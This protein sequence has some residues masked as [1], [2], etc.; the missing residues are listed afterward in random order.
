MRLLSLFLLPVCLLMTASPPVAH[1]DDAAALAELIEAH[2]Q[3][4]LGERPEFASSIGE[5]RHDDRWTD[6]A[7]RAL[8]ARH[9]AD[10]DALRALRRIELSQ[11]S[12]QAAVDHALL[13]RELAW[14]I[15]MHRYGEHLLP[16]TQ[17]HGV[18]MLDRLPAQLE[19]RGLDDYDAW[20]R[21]L[22]SLDAYIAQTMA[23]MREGM[24]RGIVV[25]QAAMRR[26]PPQLRALLVDD[27]Q[28]SG[29]YA[30]FLILPAD[31][32]PARAQALRASARAAI[33]Q[34]VLPAYRRLHDFVV[35]EYLPA[36]RERVSLEALPDG[37]SWY[38][39]RVM[40]YTSTA[41]SPQ[42][43]HAI[44]VGEVERL[45]AQM[46]RTM[47]DTGYRGE[48]AGFVARLREDPAHYHDDPVRLL[49]AFR[50]TAKRIDPELPRLF[51]R[52]PRTP[53]GLQAIPALM[54]GRG[55]AAYYRPPA[56]DGS[57]AGYVHVDV[58]H[59]RGLPIHEIA[60]LIAGESVPGRH[61]Q[62]ALAM[63]QRDL[64]PFRQH[65]HTGAGTEGWA[66]YAQG[67]GEALDLYADAHSMF[68]RLAHEM[69]RAAALVVDT[70]VHALGWERAQA[71][72][73]L[74][75]HTARAD[76]DIISEVDRYIAAPGQALAGKI[77]E[78]RI[79]A[80]RDTA[81]ERLGPGF[82]IREFHD[83]VL[84]GGAVPLDLLAARIERWMEQRADSSREES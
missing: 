13:D 33:S 8:Q 62:T 12:V 20:L 46:Q 28:D 58:H 14:R 56:V 70:G 10:R 49:E 30:P 34:R 25:P 29:F 63:E 75:A 5:R 19:F 26:V 73:Y 1:A 76:H 21:R 60:A 74:Q 43:I 35:E 50:A 23:L 79:L 53:Y 39:R 81:R 83:A 41:L 9:R 67:L 55:D 15:D 64:H 38:A 51:S 47:R 32:H 77:G 16:M 37:Q 61:L 52:L 31:I 71:I 2:W 69:W 44:G 6:L 48:L 3:R 22:E 24:R 4:T 11:L 17:L 78:L 18:Q 82:D 59:S 57:R 40:W 45:G 42:E 68:G 66:L 72:A 84:S 65:Q 27:A 36:A 7:P 54:S 80:L